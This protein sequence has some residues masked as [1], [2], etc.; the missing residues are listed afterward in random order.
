MFKCKN[1]I[2][3]NY[4]SDPVSYK[5]GHSFRSEA[6]GFFKVQCIK[7]GTYGDY[8]F[9]N[10]APT[11]WNSIYTQSW[12]ITSK[13]YPGSANKNNWI[14]SDLRFCETEGSKRFKINEK[15]GQLDKNIKGKLIQ[16]ALNL[17]DNTFWWNI[18]PTLS[19]II[20]GTKYNRD[21]P[22][23]FGRKRGRSDCVE[24]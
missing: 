15:G 5:S 2:G 3:S 22:I 19:P 16:N 6:S 8:L 10:T 12:N 20:S 14:Q 13:L 7:Q 9:S 18:R 23:L 17:L 24:V 4:L 21:K 11:H 1:G